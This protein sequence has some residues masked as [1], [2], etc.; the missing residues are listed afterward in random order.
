MA[1]KRKPDKP[2]RSAIGLNLTSRR[3][4]LRI[5]Q[6]ELAERLGISTE[7]VARFERG[8]YLPSLTMVDQLAQVLGCESA[9]LVASPSAAIAVDFLDRVRS[10]VEGLDALEREH[11]YS[12]IS[13]EAMFLRRL[14]K[15][16]R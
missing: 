9:S 15:G 3:R 14:R 12:L 10:C 1:A 2:S 16:H 6:A 13:A 7:T 5:T 4:A 8:T 11:I